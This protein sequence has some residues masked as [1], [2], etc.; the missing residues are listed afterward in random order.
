M[1]PSDVFDFWF[2][3]LDPAT[4]AP[5]E[6]RGRWWK[7]DPAFDT[8]IRERFGP[9]IEA[10]ARGELDHWTETIEGVLA[11]IILFDQFTRNAYRG[12]AAMY[13]HDHLAQDLARLFLDHPDAAGLSLDIQCF[14]VMPLMH[15][16]NPLDQER[17]VAWSAD[18]KGECDTAASP[19]A[20][21][22]ENFL[23]YAV[24]HRDIVVQW[25]RFP[26]RNAILDRA[27]TP[28]E[29]EFL[30]KPGSSF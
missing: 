30:T 16:E 12:T 4:P 7:K 2:D 29:A 26:H 27:S 5:P 20:E 19:W 28:E 9:T 21:G 8:L 25:G 14:G 10:A 13:Q 6:V 11:L 23:N 1:T 15:S 17:C 24:Q 22:M 3:G 18:R